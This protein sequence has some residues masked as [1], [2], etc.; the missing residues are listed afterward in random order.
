MADLAAGCAD[1]QVA[2]LQVMRARGSSSK[3]PSKNKG[4]EKVA[5][6]AGHCG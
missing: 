5:M 3:D 4:S 2:R 1:G 6:A